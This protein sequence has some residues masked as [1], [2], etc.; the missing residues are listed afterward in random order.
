MKSGRMGAAG[1]RRSW[2]RIWLPLYAGR[3]LDWFR[4]R[5]VERHLRH[6]PECRGA[7]EDYDGL[8]RLTRRIIM[9]KIPESEKTVWPKVAAGLACRQSESSRRAR[10]SKS[11]RLA[12][13]AAGIALAV[14]IMLYL[15][16]EP[17]RNR[18]TR[19]PAETIPARPIV[20]EVHGE[21]VTVVALQA[22]DPHMHIVWFFQDK[23]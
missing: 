13:S 1:C 8:R 14:F 10:L 12:F 4:A 9:D 17:F 15:R 21:R 11:P 22:D 23:I 6:C 3:E 7:L 20:E 5:T 18:D 19:S 2:I 16:S